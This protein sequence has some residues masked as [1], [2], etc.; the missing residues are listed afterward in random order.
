M[1]VVIVVAESSNHVIG[2]NGQIP[3]HLPGDLRR[4]RELT[5]G[6]VVIMGRKTYESLPERFR[7][8]PNRTNIVLSRQHEF[9]LHGALMATSLQ[10]AIELADSDPAF[11]I[12]GEQIYRQALP[13][14]DRIELTRVE[15]YFD[16]DSR[17]PILSRD[18]WQEVATTGLVFENDC[19]YCHITYLRRG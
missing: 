7:P 13:L 8:L 9:A 18:I 6:H 19:Q 16:G 12:G 17:F 5:T 11:V 10:E 2:R 3:W 4:F 14:A 1:S 15:D